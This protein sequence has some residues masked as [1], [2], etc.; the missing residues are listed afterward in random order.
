MLGKK[1]SINS[2]IFFIA[3]LS[4][5]SSYGFSITNLDQ[6]SSY[7]VDQTSQNCVPTQCFKGKLGPGASAAC[8]WQN[9]TC[10]CTG[11]W[12]ACLKF[13]ITNLN[14]HQS[15]TL[16]TTADATILLKGISAG[17]CNTNALG[18]CDPSL[19]CNIPIGPPG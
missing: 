1:L 7:Q 15:C 11:Q 6:K 13:K 5:F 3:S 8:N 14:T 18:N 9:S 12:N 2:I 10:N 16:T 4:A 19:N 17:Q